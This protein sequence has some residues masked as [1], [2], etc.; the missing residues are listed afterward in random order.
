MLAPLQAAGSTGGLSPKPLIMPSQN[1]TQ[2]ESFL[3]SLKNRSLCSALSGATENGPYTELVMGDISISDYDTARPV[4]GQ[5]AFT[6][7]SQWI[8]VIYMS[9]V[10]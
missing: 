9:L 8:G 5:A 2:K 7:R 1:E 3:S 4:P 6:T 10:L